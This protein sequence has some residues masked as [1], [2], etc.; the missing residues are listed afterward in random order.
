VARRKAVTLRI[1]RARF[2]ASAVGAL[3]A[4]GLVPFPARAARS[5]KIGYTAALLYAPVFV[6]VDRGYFA[7]EGFT[8]E[9][10]PLMSGQDAVALLAQGTLDVNAGG[11]SAGFL[12]AVGRGLEVRYVASMAYQPKDSHPSALMIREDL[13]DSGQV[14]GL[15]DLRGRSIAWN[16]GMG[17]TSTYYVQRIL[18]A[19][20]LTVRDINVQNLSLPDTVVA[21]TNKAVDGV[22]S[23]SPF[24]ERFQEQKLARIIAT[25]PPG[26]A[27]SGLFF[28]TNLLH[29]KPAAQAVM[30]A[31]R[32]GADELTGQKYYRPEII[33][34]LSKWST[35]PE[36]TIEHAARYDV[37]PGVP[38]DRRTLMDLQR[39][40][41]DLGI[42]SY[43]TPL[44]ESSLI[45]T[46]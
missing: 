21:F 28:G 30:R 16:G 26:I 8:P 39:T 36:P 9:L 33:A 25:V 6:A 20:K 43:K 41:I 42:V 23:S 45:E 5:L 44:S 24:T 10:I 35:L 1:K 27:S 31:V 17:S 15:A 13:W 2:A 7:A 38:V 11:L 40:F 37:P 18:A 29:D 3:V 4:P 34:I 22:Y 32:R 19:V 12:N 46:Y 14:R